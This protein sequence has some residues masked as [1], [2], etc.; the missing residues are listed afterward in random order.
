MRSLA[1]AALGAAAIVVMCICLLEYCGKGNEKAP[2]AGG[3]TGGGSTTENLTP[4]Q[5]KEASKIEEAAKAAA[6]MNATV[7]DQLFKSLNLRYEKPTINIISMDRQN[8]IPVIAFRDTQPDGQQ[9]VVIVDD[10]CFYTEIQALIESE[11]YFNDKR[12]ELI[13]DILEKL[14]GAN[15]EN[16]NIATIITDNL[17]HVYLQKTDMKPKLREH[18]IKQFLGGKKGRKEKTS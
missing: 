13:I 15:T 3:S 10:S 9:Y 7:T 18:A 16:D 11:D 14:N 12:K 8:G 17:A 6:P 5:K 4:E 1:V 2:S